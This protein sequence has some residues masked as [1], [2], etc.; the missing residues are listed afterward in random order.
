[1]ELL[2]KWQFQNGNQ[3]FQNFME[4]LH[5]EIFVL[6]LKKYTLSKM[7]MINISFFIHFKI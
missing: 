4:H 6:F 2:P 7:S 1:M 5:F 3:N